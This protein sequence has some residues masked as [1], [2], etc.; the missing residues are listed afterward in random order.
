MLIATSWYVS[1]LLILLC[2]LLALLLML[3]WLHE[4][5]LNGTA[6]EVSTC[7]EGD[8]IYND[9]LPFLCALLFLISRS[10]AAAKIT[11]SIVSSI[12]E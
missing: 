3:L 10:S 9:L 6:T 11:M 2:A 8:I 1:G 12:S 7:Y 4:V 5:R